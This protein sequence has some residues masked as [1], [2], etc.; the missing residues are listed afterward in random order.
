MD[1]SL[2]QTTTILQIYCVTQGLALIR[3]LNYPVTKI[4]LIHFRLRHKPSE[5]EQV[6]HP[7]RE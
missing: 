7:F 3:L 1:F 5:L 2:H 4:Q 6:T